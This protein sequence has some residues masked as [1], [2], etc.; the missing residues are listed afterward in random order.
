MLMPIVSATT[1]NEPRIRAAIA[2]AANNAGVDFGYLYNQA[3][4]ESS[5]DPQAKARTSSAAGLFQFTKQ[6]WLQ[7]VKAHGSDHG[8]GWAANAIEQNGSGLNV[9]DPQMRTAIDNLRYDPE[10]AS[11]MAA[12]SAS[13]NRGQLEAGLGRSA[14]PVDLYLAHFLGSTGA[15]NFLAA[16]DANPDAEAAPLFPA[17]AAANR[18][19]FYGPDGEPRSLRDIRANFAAKLNGVPSTTGGITTWTQTRR[20]VAESSDRAPMQLASIE[21]L[22]R[23]LSLDFAARA[24]QRLSGLGA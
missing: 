23:N 16:H 17:A 19:V 12:E 6:T 24:Y 3:K 13:D 14:E 21:P 7:V 18:A 10:F 9:A 4:V 2:Q 15:V 8:A 5:L 11:A 1:A 22:P 20:S